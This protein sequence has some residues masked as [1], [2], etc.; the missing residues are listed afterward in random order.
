[1]RD[2]ET[3][4][5]PAVPWA[6]SHRNSRGRAQTAQHVHLAR[7]A[8]AEREVIPAE[9]SLRAET[10]SQ[11]VVDERL[12]RK[13]AEFLKGRTHIMLHAHGGNAPR[14][15]LRRKDGPAFYSRSSGGAKVNTADVQPRSRAASTVRAQ[16]T[17]VPQV[18]AVKIAKGHTGAR[19]ALYRR[20]SIVAVQTHTSRFSMRPFPARDKRPQKRTPRAAAPA[21]RVTRVR[22]TVFHSH[23]CAFHPAHPRNSPAH[24][25]R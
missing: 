24:S 17:A 20:K 13:R 22:K 2:D 7:L 15:F 4:A 6:R 14:L 19:A 12:R 16:H 8:A 25:A 9:N 18:H 10:H 3:G 21:G 1:M 23:G 5:P 11:H